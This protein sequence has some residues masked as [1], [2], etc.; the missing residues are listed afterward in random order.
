MV[1]ISADKL[2]DDG[3]AS[4]HDT[5]LFPCVHELHY[6]PF[7]HPSDGRSSDTEANSETVCMDLQDPPVQTLFH[8]TPHMD[9]RL[10]GKSSSNQYFNICDNEIDIYSL[11]SWEESY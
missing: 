10:P 8:H 9:N 5:I 1:Y 7:L 11:C 3:F 4:V 2:Q 6:D